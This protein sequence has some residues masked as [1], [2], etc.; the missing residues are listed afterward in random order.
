MMLEKIHK[1]EK[2][3][4]NKYADL[5]GL[6]EDIDAQ[7]TPLDLKLRIVALKRKFPNKILKPLKPRRTQV[8]AFPHDIWFMVVEYLET[9]SV[10][11]LEKTCMSLYLIFNQVCDVCDNKTMTLNSKCKHFWRKQYLQNDCP[12]KSNTEFTNIYCRALKALVSRQIVKDIATERLLRLRQ[13]M[14]FKG[15]HALKLIKKDKGNFVCDLCSQHVPIT[16]HCGQK[17]IKHKK[18]FFTCLYPIPQNGRQV[19]HR[20]YC[21]CCMTLMSENDTMKTLRRDLGFYLGLKQYTV[22]INFND[23]MGYSKIVK[24]KEIKIG[25]LNEYF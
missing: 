16:N 25:F 23:N 13:N 17:C 5:L 22:F 21:I 4:V 8:Y 1:K 2:D 14:C 20:C 9:L 11:K 10:L 15:S 19:P 18:Y 24:P 6:D 12:Y 7:S 3:M